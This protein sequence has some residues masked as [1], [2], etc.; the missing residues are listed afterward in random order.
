MVTEEGIVIRQQGVYAWVKTV[1]T[2]TCE[3]CAE[4]DTCKTLGGG[5]QDME[6]EAINT[7]HAK[8]GDEV[9]IGFETASLFKLSFLIYLFPIFCMMGG[10]VLGQHLA[11]QYGWDE[12]ALSALLAF[13]AFGLAF[14]VIRLLS[15]RLAQNEKYRAR[16][17]RVKRYP[18]PP[19]AGYL[20][21]EAAI[22]E[23]CER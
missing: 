19:E 3:S 10:A 9:I 2:S 11:P 16:V 5:G 7:A 6:V 8:A 14:G 15:Y 22:G 17:L 20:P 13:A 4:R 12:S 1:R 21:P 23:S 18:A